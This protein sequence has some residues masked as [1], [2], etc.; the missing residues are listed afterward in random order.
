MVNFK[1]SASQFNME[2]FQS[3]CKKNELEFPE[4]FV[5]FIEEHN[6]AE[7][8]PNIIYLPDNECYIR[9]F[10][11]ISNEDYFDIIANYETYVDRMP[12]KCVPIADPDFGNQICMSLEKENYG[13]I[14]FWDHEIM[15]TDDDEACTLRFEDMIFLADSFEELLEMILVPPDASMNSI[16]GASSTIDSSSD[17]I[18]TS[19]ETPNASFFERLWRKIVGW[20]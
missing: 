1:N 20:F 8:E 7:L 9:Y 4:S 2:K 5:K 6:E 11:G 10:Y 19:G 17:I 16:E 3:F 12:R 14:Y 15:D 13:K 18:S